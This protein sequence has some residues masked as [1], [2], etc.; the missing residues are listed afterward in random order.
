MNGNSSRQMEVHYIDTGFAYTVTESFMDFFEGL[1]H[2][3]VNY[4][5]TGPIHDQENVYWSMNMHPYKFG[6]SGPE[7]NYYYGSY[8]VNDHLPRIE[9]SRRTWEYA[10]TMNNVEPSTTDVQSEGEA[11]MGVHT[12]PEEC[13]PHHQSSNSSQVVWQDNV[14]PDN[15]TYEELLDLGETVGTQSRGLSQEQINLL[16]TSKYKFGNLFL[17]KRSGERCVICQMKYKRG[18]RQMKLPCRHV[19]HSECITKWL[20]INKI[21]PICNNEVFGDES[22]H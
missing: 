13:S 4:A 8:E 17:R 10:S 20:G 5:Q 3:P 1:T 16:P 18:D 11:V 12:A 14:D 21:C 22:R 6:F 19:Y 7:S 2:A 9:A 15:M